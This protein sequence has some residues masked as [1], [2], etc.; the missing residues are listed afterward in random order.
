MLGNPKIRTPLIIG[1][2]AIGGL[3]C[4]YYIGQ[5][6]NTSLPVSSLVVNLSGCFLMG[7]LS[8]L[9]TTRFSTTPE[10][11]LLLTVGFLGTYTTFSSYELEATNLFATRNLQL[12]LAY[13]LG[14]P[15]LGFLCFSL[16]VKLVKD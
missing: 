12:G 7:F 15:V 11:S 5:F 14:S 13:W 9:I 2:G 4:R 16:G 1:L 6:I 10:L 8:K 3:V